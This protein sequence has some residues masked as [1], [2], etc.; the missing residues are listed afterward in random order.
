[1]VVYHY[2][3]TDFEFSCKCNSC[4]IWHGSMVW[5][6]VPVD[7]TALFLDAIEMKM[8]L[9]KFLIGTLFFQKTHS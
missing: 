5:I 8:Y 9:P 2:M 6:F 1:M 4:Q 7:S 3:L